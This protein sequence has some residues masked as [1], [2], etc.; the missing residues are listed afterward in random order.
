MAVS[1][2][3]G[4]WTRND[5]RR[6]PHDGNRYEIVR[7]DLFVTPA[8]SP[9]HEHLVHVLARHLRRYAEETGV[10]WVWHAPTAIVIAGSEV[11]P[12]LQIRVPVSPAP[13]RWEDVPAPLLVIEVLSDTTRQ[14]DLG[15]KRALY[16]EAGIDYWV[17]DD[18]KR[19]IH[20]LAADDAKVYATDLEWQ[21]AGTN[22]PLRLDV[23]ALFRE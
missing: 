15:A 10:G 1:I 8:P 23:A 22:A 14:R 21:P 19:V 13:E 17:V 4:K 2:T 11:Q 12:D 6:L 16:T 9:R 18:N 5:L 7:G 20:V 3:A